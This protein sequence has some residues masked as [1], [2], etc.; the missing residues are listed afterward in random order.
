MENL[1]KNLNE[2]SNDLNLESLIETNSYIDFNLKGEWKI[3][4]IKIEE[5]IQVTINLFDNNRRIFNN[6]GIKINKYNMN[7]FR[8]NLYSYDNLFRNSITNIEYENMKP[9][10]ILKILE[11]KEEEIIKN[12]NSEISPIQI[13][14]FLSGDLIDII[15][16]ISNN[17]ENKNSVQTK[18]LDII[19]NFVNFVIKITFNNL[20]KIKVIVNNPQYRKFIY[21]DKIFAIINSFDILIGSLENIL[22]ALDEDNKQQMD[23]T[24]QIA[25]NTYLMLIKCLNDNVYDLPLYFFDIICS[26]YTNWFIHK[27]D[28]YDSNNI[29]K[30]Y[31][32]SILNLT[33]NEL[34]NIKKSIIT[35]INKNLIDNLFD[36][37]SKM[38]IYDKLNFIYIYRCLKSQILEKKINSV[39]FI[40]EMISA[41]GENS[42]FN[43]RFVN[44]LVKEKNI[45]SILL[46]ET[47]HDEVLKRT[48]EIFHYLASFD[49]IP[50]NI[51]QQLLDNKKIILYQNIISEIVSVLPIKKRYKITNECTKDI[52]LSINE[53]IEFIKNLTDNALNYLNLNLKEQKI[54]EESETNLYGINT[55]YNYIINFKEQNLKNNNIS[56][57]IDALVHIFCNPQTIE[58]KIIYDY[59]D[60]IFH[61]IQN[62]K[63]HNSIIQCIKLIKKIFTF[64]F[65]NRNSKEL[66]LRY[67]DDKYDIITLFINDLI[68][69]ISNIQKDDINFKFDDDKI[70]EGIY[71]HSI[72]IKSRLNI[73][74]FFVEGE[75][76]E[77]V[78]DLKGEEHLEKLFKIFK[79][80]K[81]EKSLLFDYLYSYVEI[82]PDKETLE[83]F[84]KVILRNPDYINLKE[85]DEKVQLHL[86]INV[87]RKINEN[88]SLLFD[89]KNIRVKSD[90]IEGID[91]LYEILLNNSNQKLTYKIC[92]ELT[93]LCLHLI[94][95]STSFSENFWK[96]FIKDII[97]KMNNC[98]NNN[99]KIGI[100]SLIELLDCIYSN[101]SDFKGKIPEKED[102]QSAGA[103]SELYHFYFEER[104]KKEYKIKVGYKE[105]LFTVRWRIGYYYDINV[106][107]VIFEDLNG[108]K[109]NF[110]YDFSLFM[111]LFPSKIYM[112]DKNSYKCVI[113]KSES[114]QLLNLIV[115][116]KSIIENDENI[117]INFMEL[118]SIK[119]D[120]EDIK[121]K[122]WK[123]FNKL[124][125]DYYINKKII[126]LFKENT[127][128]DNKENNENDIKELFNTNDIYLVTYTLQCMKIFLNKN[129][130]DEKKYIE[131]FIEKYKGNEILIDIFNNFKINTDNDKKKNR[132]IIF[133]YLINLL[134][135]LNEIY[136]IEDNKQVDEKLCK[137]L[138]SII[139]DILKIEEDINNQEK[140]LLLRFN[141]HIFKQYLSKLQSNNKI[142]ENDNNEIKDDKSIFSNSI[143]LKQYEYI[144]KEE[145]FSS[146][147]KIL[148]EIFDFIKFL[149]NDNIKGFLE[150]L[151]NNEDLF[152]SIFIYAFINCKNVYSQKIVYKFLYNS[153]FSE[154]NL[155]NLISKYLYLMFNQKNYDY[156]FEND[157][158]GIYFDTIS[159]IISK[160]IEENKKYKYE[161]KQLIIYA[162]DK[163]INYI[164]DNCENTNK[165]IE[166]EIRDSIGSK[167]Y[168]LRNLISLNPEESVPYIL[169]NDI[170]SLFLEKCIYSKCNEKSLTSNEPLCKSY[171]S[172]T[173]IYKLI[174]TL[175][176]QNTNNC[177]DLY[178]KIIFE[179][180][181]F[182]KLGFWKS[183]SLNNWKISYSKDIKGDFCGLENLAST[184][185]LNSILQ[186]FFNIPI[187]R[188]SILSIKC[189]ENCP[190][191]YNLQIL[192]SSL[193]TYES[194]FY[195]PKDFVLL[196]GLNLIEQM[197]ADEFYGRLIDNI[198]KDINS[199]YLDDNDKKDENNITEITTNTKETNFKE[200][201]NK[202]DEKK[203]EKNEENNEENNE[204]KE[205]ENKNEENNEEKKEEN[206]NEENNEEKKEENNKENKEENNKKNKEENEENKEEEKNKEKKEEN[207]KENKEENNKENK[208]ENE[209]NK[210]EEKNEEK[211]EE[212]N[213][214]NKEEKKLENPYKNLFKYFFGGNYVDEL[215]FECGHKR[216]NE[217]FYNSIQL[218]IK[219]YMNLY[220]SLDNYTKI[221]IM[222]RDN[223]INCDICNE[224]K[225]CNKRQIFKTLPNY[226][227]I[228]LKRFEFDYDDMIKYKLNDYFEFPMDLN[229][230]KYLIEDSQEKNF[231]Y[232]L[233]GIVVHFGT[234]ESGHY[235]DFIKTEKGKW[236]EF[237]DTS[238]KEFNE[239][240]IN[241]EAFGDSDDDNFKN[242][243]L[244]NKNNNNAYI[245]I[246]EKINFENYFNLDDF[247]HFHIQLAL[248]PYN[249]L[250]NINIKI[251]DNINIE[252]FQYWVMKNISSLQYQFF[253]L[254][255]VKMDVCR[256]KNMKNIQNLE[257]ENIFTSFTS[258]KKSDFFLDN[259]NILN[260]C[261][262]FDEPILNEENDLVFKFYLLYYFNIV[263]RL[264]DKCNFQSFTDTL[265]IYINNNLNYAKFI[266]EEF[267]NINVINEYLIYSPQNMAKVTCGII[268]QCLLKI[269]D[270]TKE[271]ENDNFINLFMNSIIIIINDLI[272]DYNIDFIYVVL[273]EIISL[274]AKYRIE[275]INIGYDD[276]Y[277]KYYKNHR[278][279]PEEELYK[280]EDFELLNSSH[281]I[282]SDK[283]MKNEYM[284]KEKFTYIEEI[285]EKKHNDFVNY[286]RNDKFFQLIYLLLSNEKNNSEQEES[287]N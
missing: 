233:K 191:L 84:F 87:F 122:V 96:N 37:G 160:F 49:Q 53:N 181:N 214:Q 222:D 154:K 259:K 34:K 220:E 247:N 41:K 165:E 195:N 32:E 134:Y 47:V 255:L 31:S 243:N 15:I 69:Y 24:K 166:N 116:P 42:A 278:K 251:L 83:Y 28:G 257:S 208:E 66:Y 150:F 43:K 157:K 82:N 246:Y 76:M 149:Y 240:F 219:G 88:E 140:D 7:P 188:E 167:I 212:K 207:N 179:L 159:N 54:L 23:L 124:P 198:E 5:K 274:N 19:L 143:E 170:Y 174:T 213:K 244:N 223:K 110:M 258:M 224:K 95:Y 127:L 277:K 200:E 89:G 21:I 193:K 253:V 77:Y 46:S 211:K 50:D 229:M 270:E 18:I 27:I 118:L 81:N 72:N 252:M 204:N 51:I 123:L 6:L 273:F 36:N 151:L 177:K 153:L 206:K 39:N 109:Y 239:K 52:D 285:H 221:E 61:N 100:N 68:R 30:A 58:D 225:S 169:N 180:N 135:I 267:S 250:S 117:I 271:N 63:T 102:V 147:F 262:S 129:S 185:Y 40:N 136:Y 189:N 120:N 283:S 70:Y 11:E 266:I 280:K 56:I 279:I 232:N 249:K 228:V 281:H 236:Y 98:I 104:K 284:P 33:E 163:I 45:L 268:S 17:H 254:E 183:N 137:K 215:S 245:L 216:Y 205:E 3:A 16:R 48:I 217:F 133:D 199:L 241:F 168:L 80:L 176:K 256:Y 97:E 113:V 155:S 4:Y 92:I 238:V 161:N 9:N 184:C 242:H 272:N 173:E 64:C 286:N 126:N 148:E 144:R 186:I 194:Q 67:L 248:P 125:Y 269:Y 263:I 162:I 146:H 175:I 29:I 287:E 93:N 197:D 156:I 202:E 79:G 145:Q 152:N 192:F 103:E 209:E 14:Q 131:Y 261:L 218:N 57:A 60:E 235:Y 1:I 158:T 128:N 172:Q 171:T 230:K 35:N 25:N 164:K 260:N 111:D 38:E 75:Y 106:N 2:K 91:L 231:T 86:I 44:Y 22:Y 105:T 20:E 142:E 237:N 13:N 265:K 26:S 55:L 141:F 276:Y 227:V 94:D 65:K 108:K 74:F 190:V 234:S 59:L 130:N 275:L 226:L 138:S 201:E 203:E 196:N 139:Y 178:K 73:V 99:N 264:R 71:I 10:K 85:I 8:Y 114:N 62:D 115:N 101:A 107:D 182:H 112:N 90:K 119:N 210:E 12:K 78:L 132:F 121:E 187:L 282:L